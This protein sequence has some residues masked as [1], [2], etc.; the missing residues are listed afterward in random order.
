MQRLR[1]IYR[2]H[3]RSIWSPVSALFDARGYAEVLECMAYL[4]IIEKP[5]HIWNH[6]LMTPLKLYGP[7]PFRPLHCIDIYTM[8]L[9]TGAD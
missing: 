9:D 3:H 6:G 8:H 4:R 5:P 1:A 7:K 2:N